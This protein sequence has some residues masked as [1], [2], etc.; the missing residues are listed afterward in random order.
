MNFRPGQERVDDPYAALLDISP[1]NSSPKSNSA[2]IGS[3]T[4]LDSVSLASQA[5]SVE[6]SR[7]S[8]SVANEPLDGSVTTSEPCDTSDERT[9]DKEKDVETEGQDMTREGEGEREGGGILPTS[10]DD[11]G[12]DKETLLVDLS[13]VE[14]ED[15]E[16]ERKEESG[17][18]S[19]GA[20][21]HLLAEV[22]SGDLEGEG[23]KE[24]EEGD[25][26][27]GEGEKVKG[28]KLTIEGEE[29]DQKNGETEE[30][31]TENVNYSVELTA[32]EQ[33]TLLIQSS[34]SNLARIRYMLYMYMYLITTVPILKGGH[35]CVRYTILV[36]YLLVCK[37]FTLLLYSPLQLVHYSFRHYNCVYIGPLFDG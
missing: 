3:R 12:K 23:R 5:S 9:V 37:Y 24:E 13:N 30:K 6:A 2:S 22:F 11:D 16:R 8:H 17:A 28:G 26:R 35:P 10:G 21:Q 20:E 36:H 32:S 4:E 15:R 18:E 1:E 7:D 14:D 33:L 31:Q 25:K 27:K 34:E 29:V 19:G